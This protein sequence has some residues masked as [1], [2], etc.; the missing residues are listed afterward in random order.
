MEA[1]KTLESNREEPSG[2]GGT[3]CSD[4]TRGNWGDLAG[5][6]GDASRN[7]PYKP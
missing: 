5:S 1:V 6:W 4:R 2:V 3:E 7:R